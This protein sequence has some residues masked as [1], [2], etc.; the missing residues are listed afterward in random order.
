MMK[1]V[2][3]DYEFPG[4][5]SVDELVTQMENAWGFTAGKLA[6]GVK[7]LET[8]IKTR[9]CAKFLSFTET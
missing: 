3:K 2:I 9:N 6:V 4:K 5:M 8:M 1:D 7:I